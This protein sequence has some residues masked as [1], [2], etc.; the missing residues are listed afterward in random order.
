[1]AVGTRGLED[2]NP[3]PRLTRSLRLKLNLRRLFQGREVRKGICHTPRSLTAFE[4]QAL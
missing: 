2:A 3:S 1:M 4:L